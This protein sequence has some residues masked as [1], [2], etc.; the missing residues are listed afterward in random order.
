M[1]RLVKNSKNERRQ[2]RHHRVRTRVVGDKDCPRL[3]VFRGVD[4]MN[5]QIIDDQAGKTLCS[6]ST[7]EVK[8]SKAKVEGKK[9][10]T[11]ES[12]LAGKSLAEKAKAVGVKKVVFDRGGYSYHG[13]VAAAAEGARQGGL[14]F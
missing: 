9:G 5:L 4:N 1:K 3:S 2:A 11:A 13:R 12:F 14:E 6:V 7:V 10:K 8:K